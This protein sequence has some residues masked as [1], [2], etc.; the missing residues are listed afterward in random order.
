MTFTIKAR[1]RQGTDSLD[2]TIPTSIVRDEKI[3]AGD[4][5]EIELNKQNNELRLEYKRI[6][7]KNK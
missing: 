2:I 1:R 5:F 7:K 6:Y 4:I 3:N